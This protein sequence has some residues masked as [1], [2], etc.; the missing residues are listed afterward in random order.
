MQSY[1][2]CKE[3]NVRALDKRSIQITVSLISPKKY[4]L[5]VF[6]R[7][8]CQA[9]LKNTHNLFL[10]V[11][12]KILFFKI[13]MSRRAGGHLASSEVY[14]LVNFFQSYMLPLF[15]GGLLSYLVRVKRT[16]RHV[17]YKRDN[18]Y[19]LC[20]VLISFDV[21]GLPFG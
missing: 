18:S 20:Y 15:F 16:N 14:L 2:A 1:P 8:P 10:D 19:F 9:L 6:I 11:F 21:P 12:L 3:L 17:T 5:L 13:A 4:A 7:K